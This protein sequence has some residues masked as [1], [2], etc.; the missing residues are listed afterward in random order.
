MRADTKL[1]KRRHTSWLFRFGLGCFISRYAVPYR[2]GENATAIGGHRL[3]DSINEGPPCSACCSGIQLVDGYLGTV[4]T[5]TIT[6]A[7]DEFGHGNQAQGWVL[8][9]VR[10][11]CVDRAGHRRAG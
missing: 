10:A 9:V 2:I 5:Q 3:T 1:P 6:F 8:G 11:G 4:L 7:V